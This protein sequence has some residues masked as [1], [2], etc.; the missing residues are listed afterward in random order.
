MLQFTLTGRLAAD[1][2]LTTYGTDNTPMARLRVASN[3]P[4][5]ER[6]DFFDVAVFGDNALDALAAARKGDKVHLKGSGCQH[7]WNTDSGETRE[8]SAR[9]PLRRTHPTDRA[10]RRH[11]TAHPHGHRRRPGSHS[12]RRS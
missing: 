11:R 3:Q 9:R 8:A 12:R 7:V 10:D 5:S 6:T 2:E 4:G 1:P